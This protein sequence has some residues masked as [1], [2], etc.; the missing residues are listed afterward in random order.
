MGKSEAT[1]LDEKTIKV[2]STTAIQFY[3]AEEEAKRK[4]Q[5][6]KVLH[7]C[8]L[9]LKN[10]RKFKTMSMR[11]EKKLEA[12]NNEVLL[13]AI[14]LGEMMIPSIK[15]SK[16]KTL[17]IYNYMNA[18]IDSYRNLCAIEEDGDTRKYDVLHYLY[19]ADEKRSMEQIGQLL[20]SDKSTIYRLKDKAIEDLAV[21]MFGL[22][23][24]KPLAV[25]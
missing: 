12:I 2:I 17:A 13:N 8:E 14:T 6:N 23:A 22:N 25:E 4:E 18:I 21:L 20:V 7:N 24:I 19:F 15:K 10:Y 11:T 5:R 1:A 16:E 3:K 9:L